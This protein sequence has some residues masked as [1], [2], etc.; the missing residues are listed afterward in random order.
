MKILSWNVRDICDPK[1][2]KTFVMLRK[3]LKLEIILLQETKIR[4]NRL[5]SIKNILWREVEFVAIHSEGKS[6]GIIYLW[7][8]SKLNVQVII[9]SSKFCSI[10]FSSILSLEIFFVTN[11]YAPMTC[12]RRR[13]LWSSINKMREAF[14]GISWFVI[15]DFNVHLTPSEKKGGVEE[16]RDGMNLHNL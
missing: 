11:V 9:S 7:D 2:H 13:V 1:R 8:G 12:A 15:R 14:L 4:E 6:R 16:F 3:D 5:S 10:L